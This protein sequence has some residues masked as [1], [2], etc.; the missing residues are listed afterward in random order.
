MYRATLTP[1]LGV[2][3]SLVTCSAGSLDILWIARGGCSKAG[4][5]TG[6]GLSLSPTADDEMVTRCD[7]KV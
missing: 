2:D 6:K 5:G 7:E 1:N 3:L 4:P